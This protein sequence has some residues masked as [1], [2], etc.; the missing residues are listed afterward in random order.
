MNSHLLGAM[1]V[2]AVVSA[3]TIAAPAF[4]RSKAPADSAGAVPLGATAA[5]AAPTPA[6][7]TAETVED[8]GTARM[9]ATQNHR[10]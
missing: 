8:W 5:Q 10:Q 1:L 2:F 7:Y 6:G 3:L 9:P 4:A